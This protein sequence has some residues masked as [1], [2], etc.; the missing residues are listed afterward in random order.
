MSY[1]VL[2]RKFRPTD[3]AS[4][5]GQ[6]QVTKTLSNAI[7]RDKV[8]HA[9]LFCGPRGVGK[10]SVARILAKALN[11]EKG[12]TPQPCGKCSLCKEITSGAS[13]AV[14]EIDGASHNSVDNVRELIETFRSLPAPGYKYK[15]YI[16]DEVHMLSLAAF[17]AL[18][19]SL[20]EPPPN[21]VFILA[22]TE[23]HKIPETV[24]SRCQRHEFR[25][26]NVSQIE[27]RLEQ[28]AKAEKIEIEPQA[29]NMIA[30]L[31]DGSLR[32][33][34]SLLDRLRSFC[35]Q[36]ITAKETSQVLGVVEKNVL[37]DL[38]SAIFQRSSEKA[39][40]ILSGIF[41]T[42]I[43]PVYFIS[44]FVRH[45]RHLLLAKVAEDA[46]MTEVGLLEDDVVELKR[47][48]VAVDLEDVQDLVHIAREGGDAA[49]RSSFP[50]Y[51]LE[52]L[53][54]RMSTRM[55]SRD[56]AT[57]VANLKGTASAVNIPSSF[58][59]KNNIAEAVNS[60]PRQDQVRPEEV[61]PSSAKPNANP[62]QALD[63]R[64]FV[65][66]VGK[67]SSRILLEQLKRVNVS[68]FA[69]GSL[70][71]KGPEFALGYLERPENKQ[72]LVA[73]LKEFSGVAQWNIDLSKG[74][75]SN[76]NAE[77]G[78]IAH[79]VRQEEL[80]RIKPLEE[81]LMSHPEIRS[82][83]KAFPGSTIEKVKIY[84]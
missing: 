37:F 46:V 83:Q 10:T 36:I 59:K 26:L 1:L 62:D 79:V 17:N 58:Q 13:L 76:A 39:L 70:V 8:H 32:D 69:P 9:Y 56:L 77:P 23:T 22:T 66:F 61:V 43:S 65:A 41:S 27:S 57:L 48:I 78:S 42:G 67:G 54:V 80:D 81:D 4:V 53:I 74:S 3:F 35:E 20:E 34:Q 49:L 73:L 50:R 2:A 11:C 33:G 6:E 63:W 24:I 18:L 25:A 55:Y 40:N 38:S 72:V 45:W 29:I 16:I 30:R 60:P 19:K 51:A 12:P 64:S 14:R 31:S 82:L 7:K 75:A 52:S 5:C 21:T 47:Q 84:K 68:S 71:G 28:I 15:V 44:D